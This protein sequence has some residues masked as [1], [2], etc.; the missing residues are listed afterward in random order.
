MWKLFVVPVCLK[1]WMMAAIKVEK[2]SKSLSHCYKELWLEPT[3]IVETGSDTHGEAGHPQQVVHSLR[4]VGRVQVVVVRIGEVLVTQLDL[5]QEV[6]QT[7]LGNLE[8][9]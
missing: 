4:D 1:S 5:T 3:H 9:G 2:I 8:R 6:L 7:A